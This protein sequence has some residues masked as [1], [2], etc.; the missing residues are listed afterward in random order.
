MAW[1]HQAPSH[2]QIQCWTR[3]MP[4]YGITGPQ[5][6]NFSFCNMQ[7]TQVLILYEE[8]FNTLRQKQN[9]R[10]FADDIFKCIFL[11]ENRWVS[12]NI[13]LKF[14]LKGRINN[15]PALVQI[16]AWRLVITKPLSEPMMVSL[17]IH[18]CVTLPQWAK[19]PVLPQCWK[20]IKLQ[21]YIYISL[22]KFSTKRVN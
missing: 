5:W 11:N 19:L 1:C 4:P 15:I 2:Y 6:V 3:S 16:M 7:D 20:N 13:S 22:N 14:V 12:I 8:G 17:L 10:H 18:I 21:I 9:G